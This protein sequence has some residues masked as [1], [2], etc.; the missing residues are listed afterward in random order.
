MKVLYH[1]GNDVNSDTVFEQ[2]VLHKENNGIYMETVAGKLDFSD[3]SDVQIFKMHRLGT[4][5]KLTIVNSTIFL[6][7]PRLYINIGSGF[8]I[9]NVMATYKLKKELECVMKNKS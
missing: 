1:I 5:L 7:V 6:I 4:M 9:V 8:V 3:L 2:T